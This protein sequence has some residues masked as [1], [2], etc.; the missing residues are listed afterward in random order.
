[1]DNWYTQ[2][3]SFSINASFH[4]FFTST[5]INTHL[6]ALQFFHIFGLWTFENVR[7]I[8]R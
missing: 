3:S 2:E 4:E 5:H 7:R 6:P 1:V 8:C